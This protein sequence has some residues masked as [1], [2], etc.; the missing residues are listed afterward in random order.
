MNEH[1]L[2]SLL[3]RVAEQACSS[4]LVCRAEAESM[5][6]AAAAS[7]TA[8][9]AA[10]ALGVSRPRLFALL[11]RYQWARAAFDRGRSNMG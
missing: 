1:S 6:A 5:L 7:G 11:A 2:V 8:D 3:C 10:A 4:A 9:D